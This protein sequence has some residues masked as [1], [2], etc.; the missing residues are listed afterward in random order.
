MLA[1]RAGPV[2]AATVTRTEPFPD[3]AFPPVIVIQPALL[4]AVHEQ[5]LAVVTVTVSASPEAA[6]VFAVG[7]TA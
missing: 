1:D 5:S 3:P 4:L 2:F 7:A 6:T